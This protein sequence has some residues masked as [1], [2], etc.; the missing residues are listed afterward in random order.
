MTIKGCWLEAFGFTTGQ[1]VI[2]DTQLGGVII[3][4]EILV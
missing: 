2:I 4:G 1:P 3:R